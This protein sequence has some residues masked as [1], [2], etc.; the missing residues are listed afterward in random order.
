MNAVFPM[1]LLLQPKAPPQGVLP[2]ALPRVLHVGS[3]KNFRPEWLNLDIEP[4]WRPDFVFDIGQPLPEGGEITVATGRFGAVTLGAGTFAAIVAQD[5]LEHL[6]E[7]TTAMATMLHWLEDGGVLQIAVPYELS[8]G[9]WSDPTHVR[10]FNERSFVYYCEWFWYLG[11]QTHRFHVQKMEFVPSE[12]G[13]TL[14]AAKRP[15]DEIL[16]T[17]RAIE[18]MYVELVKRPL[19]DRDRAALAHYER[20][21][22]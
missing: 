8:L 15:Q 14:V 21:G 10:A 3:G 20:R 4:R 7:L 13:R 22:T 1:A 2:R 12:F 19:D 17:P 16:R 9:A 5:V 6:R 18:Q 11:W